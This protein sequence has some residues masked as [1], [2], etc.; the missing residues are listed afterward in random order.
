MNWAFWGT[1]S[2][3]PHRLWFCRC[4]P[5]A[6]GETPASDFDPEFA[7]LPWPFKVITATFTCDGKPLLDP[8]ERAIAKALFFYG[9][10]GGEFEMQS[11][12]HGVPLRLTI[13]WSSPAG[14]DS[15][16]AGSR[17]SQM[18][19]N[20]YIMATKRLDGSVARIRHDPDPSLTRLITAIYAT[21]PDRVLPLTVFCQQ[22]STTGPLDS[23]N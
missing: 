15:P 2:S 11:D 22:P 6:D 17:L 9:G 12:D 4:R 23:I 20:H 3:R 14:P 10:G 16:I 21:A 7:R 5:T 13:T 8:A 1:G 18:F 19:T